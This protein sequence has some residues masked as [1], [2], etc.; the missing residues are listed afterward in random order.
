MYLLGEH[1]EK[2][3]VYLGRVVENLLPHGYMSGG[4][5]YIISKPGVRQIV[6]EGPKFPADCRKDGDIEDLDIGR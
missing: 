5:A 1:Q 3:K 2:S 6:D 4:A